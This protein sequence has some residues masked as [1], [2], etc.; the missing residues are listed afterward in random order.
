MVAIFASKI[1]PSYPVGDSRS[2][3]TVRVDSV[4]YLA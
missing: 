1:P 3:A 2:D 4:T